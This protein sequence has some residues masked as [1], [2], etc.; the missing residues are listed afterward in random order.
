MYHDGVC[1]SLAGEIVWC[2]FDEDY[3]ISRLKLEAEMEKFL[4][5]SQEIKVPVIQAPYGSGKTTLLTYLAIRS[6]ELGYPAFI[7]NLS[8][9]VNLISQS[10]NRKISEDKLYEFA[11]D[12]FNKIKESV[13]DNDKLLKQYL[14][15]KESINI[16]K[17]L[18]SNWTDILDKDKGLLLIDEVEE[19]YD[20][21]RE[22][23]SYKTSPFRGL[24][25]AV[26]KRYGNIM[27]ILSYG[28]MTMAEEIA[29]GPAGWRTLTISLKPL[30]ANYILYNL[31]SNVTHKKSI[32][33]FLWWL[34]RSRPGWI[35]KFLTLGLD[36]KIDKVL[37]ECERDYSI[38]S[39]FLTEEITEELQSN[40]LTKDTKII[41][42]DTLRSD[43]QQAGD[44]LSLL[45]LSSKPINVESIGYTVTES[46]F[47]Y[48]GYSVIKKDEINRILD[49][50]YISKFNLSDEVKISIRKIADSLI[51]SLADDDNYVLY[52]E[53]FFNDLKL[54]LVSFIQDIFFQDPKIEKELD[55]ISPRFIYNSV[56]KNSIRNGNFIEVSPRKLIEYF[57]LL[58]TLPLIGNARRDKEYVLQGK[59]I[60]DFV[61]KASVDIGSLITVSR[62][63][64]KEFNQNSYELLTIPSKGLRNQDFVTMLERQITD[65]KFLENVKNGIVV[66]LFDI[67]KV[68]D[69]ERKILEEI[70]GGLIDIEK[71]EVKVIEGRDAVF[72]SG[73]IYNFNRIGYIRPKTETLSPLERRILE[74]FV[75]KFKK[76][77]AS[78]ETERNKEFP[79]LLFEL[80]DCVKSSFN[81]YTLSQY[82]DLLLLLQ[83][84]DS[85]KFLSEIGNFYRKIK[86]EAMK[87]YEDNKDNIIMNKELKGSLILMFDF[88]PKVRS[89]ES[90]MLSFVFKYEDDATERLSEYIKGAINCLDEAKFSRIRH[91]IDF[92]SKVIK[93][94]VSSKGDY[95]LRDLSS[96][97]DS[98]FWNK[99][100][101]DILNSLINGAI[102]RKA[103]DN[104]VDSNAIIRLYSESMGNLNQKFDEITDILERSLAISNE[105]CSS[106]G[107]FIKHVIE[108]ISFSLKS[109]TEYDL[110][111]LRELEKSHSKFIDSIINQ[112]DK[113]IGELKNNYEL[114]IKLSKMYKRV[115]EVNDEFTKEF[116][117][118][119]K[120]VCDSKTI[121]V[122]EINYL[123]KAVE[124]IENIRRS[125][126][127]ELTL[128]K[129][130]STS[131]ITKLKKFVGE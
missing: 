127:S 89:K 68:E 19:A 80:S 81:D 122:N 31:S 53:N 3:R 100:K 98:I 2:D 60:V 94:Y 30:R 71:A 108:P 32:A 92:Y 1:F 103:L 51:S 109:P 84:N 11:V 25:D 8:D 39:N 4:R 29:G 107:K 99:G 78:K 67:E 33:N 55:K 13:K 111:S 20:E 64:A 73:L 38:C 61:N 18:G 66:L 85:L 88:E 54:A 34:S 113:I 52:E 77:L 69:S 26:A 59:N 86:E 17:V 76:I 40:Q 117:N 102:L 130:L 90:E 35:N 114:L 74:S 116:Q 27:I 56:S 45:I 104:E 126:E 28:P 118:Y 101:I 96:I 70:L 121:D 46:Q 42:V 87:L 125:Y 119:L 43:L 22:R 10:S 62:Q 93:G 120:F 72:L 95:Q 97:I 7:I 24:Y 105:I 47:Y 44:I 123:E 63:I 112:M 57:P 12:L 48:Y 21:L 82:S 9:L 15:L 49:K 6:W 75:D 129:N 36:V 91:V 128:I 37:S 16:E 41:D 58:G 14:R 106:N 131:L 65:V 124:D 5:G 110:E 23:I 83:S 50:E 115:E 79:K